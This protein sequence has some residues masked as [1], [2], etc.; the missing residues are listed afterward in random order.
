MNG[1]AAV[2][3]LSHLNE[4]I[5]A[6][7]EHMRGQGYSWSYLQRCRSVWCAFSSSWVIPQ[8][9]A[10]KTTCSLSGKPRGVR[11]LVAIEYRTTRRSERH[12]H[13]REFSLYGCYRRR[14]C[15]SHQLQLS[16]SF[17]A[18]L[19]EYETPAGRIGVFGQGLKVPKTAHHSL[20]AVLGV[21][22]SSRCGCAVPR[23]ISP[24]S[25]RRNFT[26]P[27]KHWL[28]LYPICVHFCD[29]SICVVPCQGTW[30]HTCP[31]C[32]YGGM[33]GFPLMEQ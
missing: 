2:L 7:L 22:W 1:R 14:C 6:T 13:L 8:K 26:L 16:S 10:R 31:R 20:S 25:S 27:Q 23:D 18:V 32:A 33:H 11:R 24:I 30:V 12:A 9:A 5:E 28:S 19:Q 4:L 21:D 17:Q 29:S 3:E 15:S